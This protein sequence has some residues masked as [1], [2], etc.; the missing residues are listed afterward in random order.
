MTE[1][2]VIEPQGEFSLGAAATFG[3]GQRDATPAGDDMALAFVLDDLAHHAGVVLRQDADGVVRGEVHSD[4][5]PQLARTQVSR[6]LSLDADGEAWRAA[7]TRDPILGGLQAA[8]PGQRPVL[9]HSPYEAAAWAIISARIHHTQ[10]ADI[11]SRLAREHG[12]AFDLDGAPLHAFPL[13]QRLLELDAVPGLADEKVRRLHGVAH[14]ALDG[15]LDAGRLADLDQA[16]AEAQVQEIRG[17][18]PFWAG[19]I[20]VRSSGTTDALPGAE[21]AVLSHA[22]RLYGDGTPLDL[23]RYTEIAQAWRPF[24]TWAS[25]LIRLHG[26]REGWTVPRRRR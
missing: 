21:N 16:E 6:I 20:V 10:A 25:V 26:N 5:D 9:F 17:I 15:L 11:R 24:R 19:L 8:H 18:G 12:A 13:P 4:G 7:G 14:A 1:Q 3:F 23:A 22:G 2:I